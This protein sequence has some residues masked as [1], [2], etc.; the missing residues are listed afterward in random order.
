MF[1]A[2]ISDKE[3]Y[4]NRLNKGYKKPHVVILFGAS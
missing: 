1:E 4:R 2:N 3:N